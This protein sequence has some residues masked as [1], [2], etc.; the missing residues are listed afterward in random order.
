MVLCIC[1]NVSDAEV[2]EAIASGAQ[3]PDAVALTCRGAGNDCGRC[4]DAI[5][6]RIVCCRVA[7]TGIADCSTVEWQKA[8]PGAATA[9]ARRLP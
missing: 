4:M 1:N 3:T 5:E 8:H 2:D 7:K 9:L 6:E